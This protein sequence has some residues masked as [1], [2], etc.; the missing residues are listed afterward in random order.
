MSDAHVPL[1]VANCMK[2]LRRDDH[3]TT[4]GL[5]RKAPKHSL[6]NQLRD[7]YDRGH[8]VDIARWPDSTSLAASLLK[9]YLRSLPDPLVPPFLYDRLQ[10]A[11]VD[12]DGAVR[13]IRRRF[14]RDLSKGH[15]DGDKAVCLLKEVIKLLSEVAKSSGGWA[16]ARQHTSIGT[17][18][19]DVCYHYRSQQDELAKPS[20][21]DGTRSAAV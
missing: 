4:P 1:V 5:F 15:P 21:R 14:I 17:S 19:E 7:A 12:P 13:W 9:L 18:A 11:P 2:E 10:A 16:V 20:H 8:P 6:L 3:L